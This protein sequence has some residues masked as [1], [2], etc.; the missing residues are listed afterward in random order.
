LTKLSHPANGLYNAVRPVITGASYG[1]A[2][3][4][5]TVKLAEF[6]APLNLQLTVAGRYLDTCFTPNVL[7][8][9]RHF[10]GRSLHLGEDFEWSA[11][12][13]LKFVTPYFSEADR[14]ALARGTFRIHHTDY[15]WTLNDAKG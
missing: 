15:D 5:W 3:V 14:Q 6:C 12:F 9:Q 7:A 2:A 11:G 1:C 10:F 8:A 4:F 13:V